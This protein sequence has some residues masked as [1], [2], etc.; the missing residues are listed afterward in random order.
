MYLTDDGEKAGL[1]VEKHQ[2]LW[3]C[4][5]NKQ[6]LFE[7]HQQSGDA[8]KTSAELYTPDGYF[9]KC[10]NVPTPVIIDTKRMLSK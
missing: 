9:I 5:M 1:K 2:T 4:T 3:V 8:F 6:T 7:I 10:S